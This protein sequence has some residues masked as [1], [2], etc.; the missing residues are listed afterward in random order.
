MLINTF[1]TIIASVFLF[2]FAIQK[3]SKQIHGLVGE[4]MKK[5]IESAT[6]T[7][8][9]G[10]FAGSILTAIVQSSTTVTVILIGLVDAGIISFYNSLGIVFGANIGTT[11]TSQLVAFKIIY[12]APYIL[13]LGFIL[14]RTNGKYQKYAKTIFYFGLVLLSLLFILMITEPLQKDP[15]VLE[16]FSNISNVYVAI[17][18]GLLATIVLQSSSVVSGI[19]ILLVSQDLFDFNQAF[20]II[21]GANIGTT[22]TALIASSVMNSS[23]KKTALAHFLFNFIGVMVFIPFIGVFSSFMKILELSIEKEVALAYFIFNLANALLF[24]IFLD[25]FYR[26]INKTH[27]YIFGSDNK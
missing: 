18:A 23:A 5:I 25:Y 9:R 20:G 2:L 22:S 1:F 26:L 6:D 17:L 14:E 15:F 24:L 12:F 21:L 10:I 4:K 8:I 19:I 27:H 7:P 11:I 13:I 16:I 3:F